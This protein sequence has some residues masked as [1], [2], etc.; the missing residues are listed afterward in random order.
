VYCQFKAMLAGRNPYR[1]TFG[2][3]WSS[4]DPEQKAQIV[5]DWFK[6]GEHTMSYDP[7]WP[8]IRDYVRKGI[9]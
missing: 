6:T 5:E 3:P 8:Y 4:F 2:Q 1:Y 9:P 7:F